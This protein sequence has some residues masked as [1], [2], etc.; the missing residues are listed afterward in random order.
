M[1]VEGKV[2]G[3]FLRMQTERIANYLDVKGWIRNLSDGRVEAV[4]EGEKQHVKKLVE[5]VRHG[6]SGARVTNFDLTWEP[7]VGAFSNFKIKYT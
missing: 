7:Y 6:P 2:Q 5:F 3:V 4:F 1:T